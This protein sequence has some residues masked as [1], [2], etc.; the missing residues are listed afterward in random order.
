LEDIA[1]RVKTIAPQGANVW[2]ET[3]REPDLDQAVACLAERGR[4]V[5]MAGREARPALPVGPFYVKGC[6]M[7]GFVMFKATPEEQ[8]AAAEDLSR[9]LAS[10]AYRPRIARVFPLEEA[11][12]AHVLQEA[13]TLHRTA[14]LLGKIV[15]EMG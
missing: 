4:L 3:R 9:W 10:G 7:I 8:H 15:V 6:R 1:E 11:A 14:E 12:A 2:W 5:L 13:A